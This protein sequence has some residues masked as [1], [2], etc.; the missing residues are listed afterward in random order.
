MHFLRVHYFLNTYILELQKHRKTI[1]ET[2]A[3]CIF[4]DGTILSQKLLLQPIM[5]Y[6]VVEL[7]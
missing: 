5:N 4:Q 7:H 3:Y 2:L 1:R 6:G